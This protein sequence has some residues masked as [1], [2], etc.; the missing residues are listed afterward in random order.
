MIFN[1]NPVSSLYYRCPLGLTWTPRMVNIYEIRPSR[2]DA[3]AMAGQAGPDWVPFHL[4]PLCQGCCLF[5]RE[6]TGRKHP[7]TLSHRAVNFSEAIQY[8]CN[9]PRK[10]I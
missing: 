9:Y 5:Y 6:A 4:G 3:V 10:H 2:P 1:V 7:Q 8:S